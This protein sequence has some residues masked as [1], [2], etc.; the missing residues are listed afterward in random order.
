LFRQRPD[1]S[2]EATQ[3]LEFSSSK[4]SQVVDARCTWFDADNDG[5]RDAL[6]AMRILPSSKL[7]RKKD[8]NSKKNYWLRNWH[9]AIYHNISS[10]NHW[11]QIE[12]IGSLGNL[13]AIG[14]SV[15]VITPS[16]KQLQQ[17]GSTDGFRIS[18]GHYRLYFGLGKHNRPDLVKIF[19]PDGKVQEIHNPPGDQLLVIEREAEQVA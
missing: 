7:E 12:L 9:S 19:W 11:L 18:Q 5:F 2:F 17:V 15:M 8:S 3:L 10:G 14:A 4:K 16:G 6:I 13:Q 1:H